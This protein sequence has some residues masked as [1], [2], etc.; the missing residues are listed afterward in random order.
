[1]SKSKIIII[2]AVIVF[3]GVVL[4]LVGYTPKDQTYEP[5]RGND[6]KAQQIEKEKQ[7]SDMTKALKRSFKEQVLLQR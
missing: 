5:K 7:I 3:I 1:M 6:I 4:F 2:L